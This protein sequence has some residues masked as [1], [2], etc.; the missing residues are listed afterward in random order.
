MKR[1]KVQSASVVD[2]HFV[3]F[4]LQCGHTFRLDCQTPE[5][6]IRMALVA[7]TA[8]PPVRIYCEQCP[9][10]GPSGAEG[11]DILTPD[12]M[13]WILR[14]VQAYTENGTKPERLRGIESRLANAYRDN[15]LYI[16][17]WKE[18]AG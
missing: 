5:S 16:L 2:D 8:I 17:L 4:M 3:L 6:A 1:E 9:E 10:T 14:A 7:P 12:D 11:L 13:N 18:I 15:R